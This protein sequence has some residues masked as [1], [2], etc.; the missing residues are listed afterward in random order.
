MSEE[1]QAT[2]NENAILIEVEA[3]KVGKSVKTEL[4]FGNT[5]S[6]RIDILGEEV[7][8][9]LSSRMI[10]T[11][12]GNRARQWLE[13]ET[14]EEVIEK[15]QTWTPGITMPRTAMSPLEA[16]RK[17]K[18]KLTPEQRQQLIDELMNG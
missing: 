7:V 16:I 12:A 1:T 14:E 8:M 3:P 6:E 10:R 15:L 11:D 18:E 13:N 5:L 9:S 2:T 17:N 4:M